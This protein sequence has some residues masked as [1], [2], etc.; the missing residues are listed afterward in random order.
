MS[1]WE[2]FGLKKSKDSGL[3]LPLPKELG[4]GGFVIVDTNGEAAEMD[5]LQPHGLTTPYPANPSVESA[6]ALQEGAASH[7]SS[8][9]DV[10]FTLA[11]R[12]QL[13]RLCNDETL[14]AVFLQLE[15]I[16]EKLASYAY[17]FQL[18]LS[19]LCDP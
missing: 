11:P 7:Q 14:T 6:V 3:P 12:V 13:R 15:Q 2:L 9:G 10:P 17:D 4:E 16:D 1:V 19:V 18:E 5:M 8:L